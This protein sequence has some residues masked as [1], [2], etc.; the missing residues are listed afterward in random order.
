MTA[1]VTICG[2]MTRSASADH[3]RKAT[4][5]ASAT[6]SPGERIERALAL[7]RLGL[8]LY[9]STNGLPLDQARAILARRKGTARRTRDLSLR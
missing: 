9:A 4:R 1:S 2:V 6:Q 3:F 8:E 5:A 7:G